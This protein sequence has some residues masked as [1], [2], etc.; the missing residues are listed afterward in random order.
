MVFRKMLLVFILLEFFLIMLFIDSGFLVIYIW[1]N[2][3]L[4]CVMCKLVIWLLF[5]FMF[6]CLFLFNFIELLFCFK[7]GD[8][9][10]KELKFNVFV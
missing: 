8:D 10:V 6:N 9:L 2:L 4:L 5:S 3:L 1:F 7:L